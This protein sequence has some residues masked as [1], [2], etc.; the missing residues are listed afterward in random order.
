MYFEC[1]VNTTTRE[2]STPTAHKPLSEKIFPILERFDFYRVT[3]ILTG[4]WQWKTYNAYLELVETALGI[5]RHEPKMW[6]GGYK[7]TWRGAC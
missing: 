4:L 3:E 1:R 5:E 7:L 2:M 6:E